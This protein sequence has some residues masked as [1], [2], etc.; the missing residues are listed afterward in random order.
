MSGVLSLS[1][2]LS[3]SI[4]PSLSL[5]LSSSLSAHISIHRHS[6]SR[7]LPPSLNLSVFP[8]SQPTISL[9]SPVRCSVRLPRV[10]SM[11]TNGCWA[12][13]LTFFY[14][15]MCLQHTQHTTH[16]LSLLDGLTN[17]FL[18]RMFLRTTLYIHISMYVYITIAHSDS[19]SL[20]T[21]RLPRRSKSKSTLTGISDVRTAVEAALLDAR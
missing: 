17:I 3:L 19:Y 21:H 18:P 16:A 6:V 20:R 14:P 4:V 7:T 10:T 9:S 13:L 12:G 5:F 8:S 2:S 1:L 15:R 11:R